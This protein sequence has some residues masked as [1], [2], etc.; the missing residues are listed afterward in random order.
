[1][2]HNLFASFET[3]CIDSTVPR[4][5]K[6]L[7]VLK[8]EPV[9]VADC[10]AYI[11]S[12]SEEQTSSNVSSTDNVQ[13]IIVKLPLINRLRHIKVETPE[14]H[15][16]AEIVDAGRASAAADTE[17]V[18]SA[19]DDAAT[20][21]EAETT[22]VKKDTSAA[23]KGLQLARETIASIFG[24]EVQPRTIMKIP[25]KRRADREADEFNDAEQSR[26]SRHDDTH[27][28]SSK[29]RKTQLW[30]VLWLLHFKW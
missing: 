1:V 24:T 4:D 5:S 3:N 6:H 17:P 30:C 18:E 7:L 15:V 21:E 12:C 22:D 19:T 26:T 28:R 9:D 20:T 25:I 16:K 23:A 10:A 11:R 29:K 27:D 14:L 8:S 13:C 2:R